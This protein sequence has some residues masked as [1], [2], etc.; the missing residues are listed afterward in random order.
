[1]APKPA[2]NFDNMDYKKK[3]E[4][5][6]TKYGRSKAGNI[7]QVTEFGKQTKDK[8]IIN[9]VRRAQAM[10]LESTNEYPYLESQSRQPEDRPAEARFISQQIP[11]GMGKRPCYYIR[12]SFAVSLTLSIETDTS[13]GNLRC[14]YRTICRPVSRHHE[15]AQQ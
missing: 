10:I 1:M 4:M 2:I 5:R 6:F 11:H 12:H 9:I 13:P 14:L 15:G 8:G 7:L 3:D